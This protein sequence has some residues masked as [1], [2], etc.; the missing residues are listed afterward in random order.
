VFTRNAGDV[1]TL[2]NLVPVP[3]P[4]PPT[5]DLYDGGDKVVG[6]GGAIAVSLAV[7]PTPLIG[8]DRGHLYAGAWELYP[9][10][11]WCDTY[12]I[13]VGQ[14]LVSQRAGFTVTGLNVQAVEDG[15]EVRV[16]D[17]NDN[18]LPGFDPPPILSEGE[19]FPIASGIE[20]GTR[21]EASDQVQVQLFTGN[22]SQF[23]EARAYTVLCRDDWGTEYLAPR[24]SDGNFWLYN[25]SDSPLTVDVETAAGPQPSITVPADGAASYPPD[26]SVLTERSGVLFTSSGE[27]YGVAALDAAQTQDWGYSL[28]PIDFLTTQALVGWAPGN[29]LS[30][31]PSLPDGSVADD[32]GDWPTLDG[33]EASRVYVTAGTATT[34]NVNYG[35]GVPIRP[36]PVS[37]LEEVYIVD[38]YPDPSSADYDMTGAFLYTEDG[39]RF[40]AVWGQDESAPAADPSIDVGTNIAPLRA[41][42]LEKTYS[43]ETAGYNCGTVSQ[44]HTFLFDLEAYN[45]SAIDIPN[46]IV[47]D[48]L[49]QEFTYV[50]GSTTLDGVPVPDNTSGDPFPLSGDGLSI[51]TLEARGSALVSFLAETDE[52]GEF[53]NVGRLSPSAD[54]AAVEVQVPTLPA[55]YEVFKTLV[56]PPS[57]PAAPGQTIT[58]DV[59]ISNTGSMT[60][61]ELPLRDGFEPSILTF[62]SA[63]VPPSSV[64][65]DLGAVTWDDLTDSFG[66]LTPSTP[67][68]TLSVSF[69]VNDD[70]PSGATSTINLA[71]SAGGQASDRVPQAITCA[72]AQVSLDVPP[73]PTPIPS[74]TPTRT[75]DDGDGDDDEEDPTPTPIPSTSVA[76]PAPQPAPTPA[77]LFLPET[78]VGYLKVA[79]VWPLVV[80]PGF[81]LLIGWIV[82]RRRNR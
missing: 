71:F 10:S 33:R 54:P 9:T 68:Q 36:V 61:T 6:E 51:G 70:L 19:N 63:S 77:V 22:P 60:I 82:Y 42:S 16:Y 76:T 73:T 49:P 65:A 80:L 26:A 48:D 47:Q 14:D 56:D 75:P 72:E 38:D 79:P 2:Q 29:R 45:D 4:D 66:D 41:P 30:F 31:D 74:P 18:L 53:T 21:V 12:V 11:R 35:G 7:W 78:G 32:P 43:G 81:G 69:V 23:Y 17:R 62:S 59:V 15:T 3:R 52:T 55:G 39:V 64:D 57:G 50:L 67:P 13:P 8:D 34:I 40:I 58:F 25:D 5:S 44:S 46:A 1:I 24:G 28:L 37:P 20:S 27:F